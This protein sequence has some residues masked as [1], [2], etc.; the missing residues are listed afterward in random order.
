MPY[1]N[2]S[3]KVFVTIG[4]RNVTDFVISGSISD[5]STLSTSIIK[6]SGTI[7][8]GGNHGGSHMD[9]FGSKFSVGDSVS[10][11]VDGYGTHPRGNMYVISQS[12]DIEAQ[13]VSIEVGCRLQLYSTY[14]QLFA[15]EIKALFNLVGDR[16][17]NFVWDDYSLS[18]LDSILQ[19][20]GLAMFANKG[21]AVNIINAFTALKGSS[22]VLTSIDQ[23]TAIRMESFTD[24]GASDDPLS[25][26]I[27]YNFEL[28]KNPQ[29]KVEEDEDEWGDGDP[30]Q[31][32]TVGIVNGNVTITTETNHGLIT[33]DTVNV[34][35][36][37]EPLDPYT[38]DQKW[39]ISR[40]E[41][42]FKINVTGEKTF[43]YTIIW[44][45]ENLSTL[46][47]N[48]IVLKMYG[49]PKGEPENEQGTEE[50]PLD[51]TISSKTFV[52]TP[53]IRLK[54]LGECLKVYRGKKII[55]NYA[56][57]PLSLA[58]CGPY[59]NPSYAATREE[60]AEWVLN[61][62]PCKEP[63]P[64]G[65]RIT[66]E[67]P[68]K[69]GAQGSIEVED[70]PELAFI[71][72][73]VE[74]FSVDSFSGPG[75][76]QDAAWTWENQSVWKNSNSTISQWVELARQLFDLAVEEANSFYDEANQNFQSRDDNNLEL[77]ENLAQCAPTI[78]EIISMRR[79]FMFYDCAGVNAYINAENAIAK[80]VTIYNEIVNRLN[81][82]KGRRTLTNFQV[83]RNVF[84]PGGELVRKTS[85][86]LMQRG[87]SHL[88]RKRIE[89]FGKLLDKYEEDFLSPVI[90]NVN[91]P[92]GTRYE[93]QPLFTDP[94]VGILSGL[95]DDSDR[96]AIKSTYSA[97]NTRNVNLQVE[98]MYEEE[99]NDD[100]SI[101]S[102]R[103]I[104]ARKK[105]VEEYV[106]SNVRGTPLVTK[107]VTD[108]DYENPVNSTKTVEVST[109]YATSAIAPPANDLAD[110]A[111][112]EEEQEDETPENE[113][114]NP[115]ELETETRE[116]IFRVS[117]AASNP[118]GGGLA[119]KFILYDEPISLPAQLRPLV[120]QREEKSQVMTEEDCNA[121]IEKVVSE[122]ETKLAEYEKII[123]HYLSFEMLK[124]LGDNRGF[125]V[126]EALRAEISNT[127]PLMGVTMKSQTNG[128]TAY[129][130]VSGA[131][132]VFNS[133]SALVALD[134]YVFGYS[135][136]T[137]Y[138]NATAVNVQEPV[139]IPPGEY[140]VV[141]VDQLGASR[142]AE[143]VKL[144]ETGDPNFVYYLDDVQ[145]EIGAEVY[146]VDIQSG[147]LRLYN[148]NPPE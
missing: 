76:Q 96:P 61:P 9:L 62:D 39:S 109:N 28:P 34:R 45:D 141:T 90:D 48:G 35:I 95:I 115:C 16:L 4:G 132:W 33:G 63:L 66:R 8:L 23:V 110:E 137:P 68:Y 81:A 78:P 7:V 147:R 12:S 58:S 106:Y 130:R 105:V 123:N 73:Y 18:S 128:F 6:S 91:V 22:S 113:D 72:D 67:E 144:L 57:S 59:L 85:T 83:T 2:T 77:K 102:T 138:A 107:T 24:A 111:I 143:K 79:K 129:G 103:Q 70:D 50:N 71:S 136:G 56:D 99:P 125:R 44:Q 36:Y 98:G 133:T 142:N 60:Y 139:E 25:L 80:A 135:E 75:N 140:T 26:S 100:G 64:P 97:G 122:A 11:S 19:T 89:Q 38:Q 13:T 74:T 31:I 51:R 41:G 15:D 65:E 43:T 119:S 120:P 82:I 94:Q 3:K 134:C 148:L 108:T 17:Q 40:A 20:L 131:N 46:E 93:L 118:L 53:I 104:V 101:G 126:T 88:A 42:T 114:D 30:S 112:T 146:I 29:E 86:D 84:G 47:V 14:E 127:F 54:P 145:L 27:T 87:A 69:Y 1:I 49:P 21:G 124:R 32:D 55:I 121:S 52:K 37:V 117:R 10:I 5:D 116:M 92:T